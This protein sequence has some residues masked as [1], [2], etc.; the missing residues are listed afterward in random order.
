MHSLRFLSRAAAAALCAATLA[1]CSSGSGSGGSAGSGASGKTIKIGIDLPLSGGDASVGRST[2]NGMQL[3]I[4]QANKKGL[5]GGFVLQV[6]SA[7]D[8]VQGVHSPQQGVAN[9]KNFVSDPNV[10]AVLGPYN[11]N[12]AA[13]EIPVTN[14][15]GLA[16]I[17]PSTVS[18]NLTIGPGAQAM[19]RANPTANSFFRVC[20]TDSR[21]GS[22]AAKFALARGFKKAYIIDDNETYGLDLADVFETDFQKAGGTVLGHD[23]IA[24]NTQDFKSLLTKIAATK[25]DVVFYGGTTSTGAGLIRQQ[26]FDTGLGSVAFMGGDGIPD[27]ASVA[28]ARADGTFYTLAAP[29]AEKLPSAQTFIK[30]YTAAY[31]SGIGPYSANGYAAA[32]VAADAVARAIKA[33]GNTMPTRA[34]I[35]EYVAKTADL[36]TPIGPISFDANGDVKEPVLSLYT[37]KDGKPVFIGQMDL[38]L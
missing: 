25:P 12:V 14:A 15:A 22:A 21:Q 27:I 16:Q 35:I 1:A 34:Q 4:D 9:V 2:L 36:A 33:G 5:P 6:V 32:Q 10:L 38:K 3:A 37:I 19:R 23:H 28:G 17:A 20:T 7:D 30:D 13:A 18:D 24:K 11:S 29:N 31:H 26:M 8:A